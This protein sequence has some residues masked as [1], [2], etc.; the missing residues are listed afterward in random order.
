M[1]AVKH[2]A[3]VLLLRRALVC[4]RGLLDVHNQILLGLVLVDWPCG[5]VDLIPIDVELVLTRPLSGPPG[6][7]QTGHEPC[8]SPLHADVG[9]HG[10]KERQF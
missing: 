1:N 4:S 10:L 6:S 2:T 7:N 5:V 8:V 3:D 9:L